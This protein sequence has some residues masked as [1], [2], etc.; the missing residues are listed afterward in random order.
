MPII[1]D[2]FTQNETIFLYNYN[3]IAIKISLKKLRGINKD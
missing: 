1:L 3:I 2:W